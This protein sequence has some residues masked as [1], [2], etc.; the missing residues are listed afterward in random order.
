MSTTQSRHLDNDESVRIQG[1]ADV[2][3]K[4]GSGQQLGEL[5]KEGL[6]S[7]MQDKLSN[8]WETVQQKS[9][10]LLGQVKG[11]AANLQS[12]A[13]EL[14]QKAKTAINEAAAAEEDEEGFQEVHYTKGKKR[15]NAQAT[16]T[17]QQLNQ[18]LEQAK[19]KLG[20]T[21]REMPSAAQVKSRF[22]RL[23]D[24]QTFNWQ[25]LLAYLVP[26]IV[27]ALA[28]TAGIAAYRSYMAPAP[29]PPLNTLDGLKARANLWGNEAYEYV[30]DKSEDVLDY[31]TEKTRLLTEQL[32]SGVGI[33]SDKAK[34]AVWKAKDEA[35]EQ[36][37]LAYREALKKTN[38]AKKL[39]DK[40]SKEALKEL[41]N[42]A[43]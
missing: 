23:L 38:E 37:N 1:P 24:R 42:Y 43:K 5:D 16:R 20:A 33:Y 4:R 40:K 2:K 29:L 15:L 25:D 32:K 34:E 19:G 39:A 11:Q 22:A 27:L 14:T 31:A 28:L 13:S 17:K 36:A 7:D 30:H 3:I 35:A 12:K 18:G 41:R 10:E 6:Q 9:S 26:L 21:L 8:A